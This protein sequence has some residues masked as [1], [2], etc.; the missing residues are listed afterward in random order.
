MPPHSMHTGYAYV[1]RILLCNPP[2]CHSNCTGE[3]DSGDMDAQNIR[4]V[5]SEL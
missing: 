4:V 3:I 5:M 2:I 1:A